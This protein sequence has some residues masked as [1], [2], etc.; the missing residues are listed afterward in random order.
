MPILHVS[1]GLNDELI[2]DILFRVNA[3]IYF[4]CFRYV[5]SG[6][7][8]PQ[9]A[10]KLRESL[11]Y[12]MFDLMRSNSCGGEEICNE[13]EALNLVQSAALSTNIRT[14]SANPATSFAST[15][16]ASGGRNATGSV[17]SLPADLQSLVRRIQTEQE[18][19]RAR[20]KS[21]IFKY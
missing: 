16:A 3:D 19:L 5:I 18:G 2:S 8:Q 9:I 13:L 17:A 12:A 7:E 14:S 6:S 4:M 20:M 21:K 10:G 1:P 11:E 15:T